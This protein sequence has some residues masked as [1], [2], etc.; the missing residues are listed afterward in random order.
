MFCCLQDSALPSSC[1]ADDYGKSVLEKPPVKQPAF[2]IH[3][4]E[5]DGA[6]T[7]KTVSEALRARAPAPRSPVAVHNALTCRQPLAALDVPL[8]VEA[9]FGGLL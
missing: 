7:K 1:K 2:Q 4:D 3:M 8:V 5:P 9:G 6:C